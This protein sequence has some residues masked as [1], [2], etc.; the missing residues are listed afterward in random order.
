MLA[1]RF[2][3]MLSVAELSGS[4]DKTD[5]KGKKETQETTLS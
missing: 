3:D 2:E 1:N 4:G 5:D